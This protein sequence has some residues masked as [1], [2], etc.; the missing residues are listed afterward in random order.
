MREQVT[1]GYRRRRLLQLAGAGS[2]FGLSGCIANAIQ[3]RDVANTVEYGDREDTASVYADNY[4]NSTNGMEIYFSLTDGRYR[5]TITKVKAGANISSVLGLDIV[6]FAYFSELDALADISE[7]YTSLS[8]RDDFLGNVGDL[9]STYQGETHAVPFW[10]DSSLYF[11]NKRHFEQAGLDPE[12]PPTTWSAFRD[13]LETLDRE[14]DLNRPPLGAAFSTGLTGFFGYPFIWSNGGQI[15]NE[16]GTRAVFH[17]DSSV[18]A[19]QYWVDINDS[20]LMT[21]PLSTN[22]EDWHSMFTNGQISIMFTGGLGLNTVRN[23]NSELFENN[24]GTAMFPKPEGG[25][26]RSFLGGNNLA[27]TTSTP[28]GKRQAAENFLE[29]V[30]SEEGMQTTLELGFMPGRSRGF[31][32][33]IATEDPYNSL[34]ESYRKTLQ[35]GNTPIY[36]NY[37]EIDLLIT[38][39]WS[40]ALSGSASPQQALT[41]AAT[42]VNSGVLDD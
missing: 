26:R 40:K 11:Y 27:I 12:N 35:Q 5:D 3:P 32:T 29:W 30:N 20:G 13:A 22:W 7:F 19:L 16:D 9:F 10:I 23:S 31:E 41:E 4:N 39:A 18:E 28:D 17:E 15:V 8:Y 33:G 1:D 6:R 2:M 36:P 38:N 24:L 34:L 21:N 25:T 37:E 14:L 42:E